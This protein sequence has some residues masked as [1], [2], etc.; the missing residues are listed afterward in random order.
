MKSHGSFSL[1]SVLSNPAILPYFRSLSITDQPRVRPLAPIPASRRTKHLVLSLAVPPASKASVTLPLVEAIFTLVDVVA[2][3]GGWG[4]GRGQSGK[5]GVGLAS[6]LRPETKTKLR[7]IREKLDKELK[8][9]AEKEKR[10]EA[11]AEK[12]AA[13]KKAEDERLSKLSAAE[14]K[15]VSKHLYVCLRHDVNVRRQAMDREKKRLLRKTQG[16]VKMR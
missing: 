8:E 2:G 6:S 11:D 10:E 4:I 9:E 7:A 12:A 5:G 3:A 14:Q 15:K 1:A 16:K 13:K